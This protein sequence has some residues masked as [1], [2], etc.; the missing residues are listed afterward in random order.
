MFWGAAYLIRSTPFA[1]DGATQNGPIGT[2]YFD[3]VDREIA[4]DAQGF[5]GTTIR[6]STQYDKLW[7]RVAAKPAVFCNGPLFAAHRLHRLCAVRRNR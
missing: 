1:S 4:R 5:D 7:P 6:T 3:T 2:I